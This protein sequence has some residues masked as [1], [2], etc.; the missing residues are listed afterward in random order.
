LLHIL[1]DYRQVFV[2]THDTP[3]PDAIAGGWAL[4]WLV[5]KKLGKPARLFGGGR[6]VRAENKHMLELLHPPLE[7]V[8]KIEC[9]PDVALV[10][11]DCSSG[12][13]N[14]LF[15]GQPV[16]PVAGIDHH[17]VNCRRR[18]RLPFEDIR[19]KVVASATI[20]A[21]YLREQGLEPS[22]ELAT[23]LLYAIH[24][25]TRGSATAYSRADRSMSLWLTAQADLTQLAEIEN[26]PLAVEYFADLVLA[27]QNTMLYQ[28]A[29]FCLLPRASGT[30]IVGEV[31][32]LL[33]R[34]QAVGRVLCGAVVQGDLVFS[35]RTRPASGDATELVLATLAGIGQG[36]GHR[37][38]AGGR[39]PERLP[40]PGIEDELQDE[41][42]NR[43][44]RA[45]GIPLQDGRYLVP[46]KE[47]VANL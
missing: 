1:A 22:R 27:L 26:A 42:R 10:L 39:I 17:L 20:C 47:I 28:D 18:H 30:E 16:S 37:H 33:I 9:P 44:L 34:C 40:G 25:E 23:A 41:L 46:R 15:A 43:W 6:I 19:P 4:T 31:A 2:V 7:L 13:Q 38:R 11:I 24:T 35:V 14:H 45:C 36:G 21:C 8:G 32:D 3:D 5:E 12:S 29:A